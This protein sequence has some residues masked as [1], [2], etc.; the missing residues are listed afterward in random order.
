MK[1][2]TRKTTVWFL[3][4]AL[5]IMPLQLVTA[6]VKNIDGM[7]H[8]MM[9]LQDCQFQHADQ[10][11]NSDKAPCCETQ[12]YTCNG[13][14]HCSHAG[15]FIAFPTLLNGLAI[16][17]GTPVY[18]TKQSLRSGIDSGNLLRPPKYS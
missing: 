7:Q 15:S 3:L 5:I 6:S 8:E 18:F 11:T 4:L 13:L 10:N 1:F 12:N 16:Q 9:S 2:F 17:Q 14:N